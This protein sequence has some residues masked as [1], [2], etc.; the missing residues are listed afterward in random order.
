MNKNKLTRLVLAIGLILTLLISS[1]QLN[2]AHLYAAD[3]YNVS[4]SVS[5]GYG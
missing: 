3:S 1:I 5:G 4:A 2:V